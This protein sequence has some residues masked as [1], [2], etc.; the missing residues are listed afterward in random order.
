MRRTPPT[1]RPAPIPATTTR[2]RRRPPAPAG[3]SRSPA[4]PVYVASGLPLLV[5][6][7]DVLAH[8]G[9]PLLHEL[10]LE[11]FA[12]ENLVVLDGFGVGEVGGGVRGHPRPVPHREGGQ[13]SPPR[14]SYHRPAM[15]L[16]VL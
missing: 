6:I 4:I 8:L 5:C 12:L 11:A 2:T 14:L 10:L 13:T 1:R 3:P 16:P 7:C 15:R 9:P